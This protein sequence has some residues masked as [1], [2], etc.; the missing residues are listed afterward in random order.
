[1]NPNDQTTILFSPCKYNLTITFFFESAGTSDVNILIY[2]ADNQEICT[3][4]YGLIT[5]QQ[6]LF[7]VE[8]L[9]TTKWNFFSGGSRRFKVT[10]IISSDII[11]SSSVKNMK[12]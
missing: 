4:C 3:D 2:F 10:G 6:Y 7:Y 12:I 8:Q 1:M 9:S 11:Y 5:Q